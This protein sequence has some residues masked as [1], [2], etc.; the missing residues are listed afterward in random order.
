MDIDPRLEDTT[1]TRNH[2]I[3]RIYYHIIF[4]V[5]SR[6]KILGPIEESVYCAF[7]ATENDSFKIKTL[8]C[9]LDHIHLLIEA[10]PTVSVGDIIHRMKQYTTWYLYKNHYQYLRQ[11]FWGKKRLIWTNG[12]FCSTVGDV[13]K[14]TVLEY[15]EN[16][17]STS[18]HTQP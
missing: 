16:Q 18:E 7:R 9:D 12:Y 6:K 17:G 13:S 1:R 10:V 15:I 2:F 5:K 8:K 14:D 3:S 11:F 4:S